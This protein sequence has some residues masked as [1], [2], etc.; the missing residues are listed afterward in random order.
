MTRPAGGFADTLLATQPWHAD[1]LA[2]DTIARIL[3]PWPEDGGVPG[4]QSDPFQRIACVN[5]LFPTGAD[6]GALPGWQ[7]PAGVPDDIGQALHAYLQAG[8]QL[9]P[10]ADTARIERA[11]VLFME[12]GALSCVLLFCASLP[13]CYVIPDL[14]SVLHIAG[15]LEQHTE[16]RIRATAAMIFPVMMHG[17]LTQPGGAGVAQ[18]LKVRL[19][20]AT[21]R[22]LILRGAPVAGQTAGRVAPLD[23]PADASLYQTL[24]T[25]GW[26]IE[27]QGLPCNQVELA[28][29]LLTFGY[30]FLRSLRRLGIG[31]PTAD[32]EAYLHAWNVV[33]HVLGI[34]DSLMAHTMDEAAELLVRLQAWGRTQVTP[35]DARPAL[36]D[37]LM[38]T[39]EQAVPWPIAR[40]FPRLMTRYLCGRGVAGELGLNDSP[41]PWRSWLLFWVLLIAA[42]AI[43][44]AAR[45]IWPQFS[46]ARSFTRVLGYHFLVKI[47]MDQTRPLLLPVRLL[48]QIGQLV[49]GW[50][51]DPRAPRW[52]NRVE[53]RLTT[54][55]AWHP[56]PNHCF[57]AAAQAAARASATDTPR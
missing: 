56:V 45:R 16:H 5:R 21:I 30:V 20:H 7:P 23:R 47:L 49:T 4:A 39:M 2:D 33:G 51:D 35:P 1:P 46:L 50:S 54:A 26:D 13:E 42:R 57:P 55:G 41:A 31:L 37:A 15:G 9:P 25:H 19:I 32:E 22:H 38:G 28:Y 27:R 8:Q 12:Y 53:D 14:A 36:A 10:W 29:T 18:V 11:E 24:S 40:P 17:G 44:T 48:N 43:D 52:L 3:G 6:N 34:E